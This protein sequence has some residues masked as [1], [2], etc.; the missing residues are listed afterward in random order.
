MLAR[1]I[2]I[3][4]SRSPPG[5]ADQ[6]VTDIVQC[7]LR[8]NRLLDVTGALMFT[9]THFAQYIEGP[10]EAVS[11]LRA[12]IMADERHRDIVTLAQG[13][14]PHRL[15]LNW[16]LAYAGPSRFVRKMV[17]GVLVRVRNGDH[18]AY[19]DL[20]DLMAEFVV[21]GLG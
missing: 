15:F 11:A 17:E 19:Q 8:R 7:S 13:P 5:R 9:G 2:Y 10:E 1:W 16:S 20:V 18:A 3:S 4:I 6:A 21:K 14:F 12:S